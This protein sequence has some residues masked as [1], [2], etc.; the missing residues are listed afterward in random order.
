LPETFLVSVAG[1]SFLADG[2]YQIGPYVLRG[3]F[4]A[5]NLSLADAERAFGKGD[6]CRMSV[7]GVSVSW[8]SLGVRG[9]FTT[10]GGF[11]GKTGKPD[12]HGI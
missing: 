11:V 7:G 1:N 5:S 6:H 10:L 4:N 8:P 3:R 2:A 9:L 12:F